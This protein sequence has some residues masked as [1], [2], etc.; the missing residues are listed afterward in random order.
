MARQK[1]EQNSKSMTPGK[2]IALILVLMLAGTDVFVILLAIALVVAPIA[3]PLFF[4]FQRKKHRQ[5]HQRALE[6]T[7]FTPCRQER[8][9][10]E[11]SRK[12]FCFHNDKA[13][14]HVA[15]GREIDPWERPDIDISKYQRKE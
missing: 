12:L 9:F 1:R 8:A 4:Y 5:E 15:R 13:I 6:N 14:H 7:T 2:I 11:Q 10:D 3:I